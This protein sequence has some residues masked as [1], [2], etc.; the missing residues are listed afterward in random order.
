[1]LI[2]EQK[3]DE[4]KKDEIP[5]EIRGEFNLPPQLNFYEVNF[6]EVRK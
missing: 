3:D 4:P 2:L 6:N 1:M 5:D